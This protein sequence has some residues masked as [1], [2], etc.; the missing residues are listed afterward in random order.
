MV[1]N[2]VQLIHS[3]LSGDEQAFSTLVQKYQK[4]VH[5]LAWRKIGDFHIAEEITQD[6]FLQAYKNLATLR[7]PNQFAGWLYVIANRLC[8]KWI[9]KRK[10]PMQSLENMPVPEV[11]KSAYKRYV[12]E[13]RE[14]EAAERRHEIV[15]ELLEKLPESERTVVTLYYLGEMTTTEISKFLGVSV[16]TIKSRLRRARERLQA[17]EHLISETLE[18]VQL[19]A[20]LIEKIMQQ[21]ADI[22]PAS[23]SAGKPLLPWLAFGTAA[24][25]ILLM[26]GFGSE[27]LARFQKPYNLNA[28]SETTVEIIEAP[29]VLDTQ[30]EPDVRN[31]AGSFDT[32]GRS[33]GA[34]PQTS[35]PVLPAVAQIEKQEVLT[36]AQQQ[37]T[38]A[39]GPEGSLI[40]ELFVSSEGDIY[41]VSRHS[42][43]RLAPDAPAWTF[44]NPAAALNLSTTFDDPSMISMAEQNGTLYLASTNEVFISTDSG[45]AWESLGARPDGF[46]VGLAI[47]DEALYLV[48]KTNGIFRSVDAGKQ[49][50]RVDDEAAERQ[51]NAVATLENTVFVGTTEGLYRINPSNRSETGSIWEKLPLTSTKAIQSLATAENTLY[52]GTGPD[53]NSPKE[54]KIREELSAGR[55]MWEIF[56]STDFGDSWIEITPASAGDSWDEITP[57]GLL[58]KMSPGIK[59]VAAG[60]TL[61]ALGYLGS[62]VR[63]TDGGKTWTNP[64]PKTLD[65]VAMMNSFMLSVCPTVGVDENT[66]FKA[67][68]WGLTRSTDGGASWHP[69][70]TGMVGTRISDLVAFENRLYAYTGTN[71]AKSTDGGMSWQ[72]LSFNPLVWELHPNFLFGFSRLAVSDDKLYGIARALSA[73]RDQY[74]IFHLST[75]GDALELIQETPIFDEDLSIQPPKPELQ[76]VPEKSIADDPPNAPIENFPQSLAVSAETFYVVYKRQLFRWTRGE[77]EWFNTGLMDTDKPV[78]NDSPMRFALAV[79]GETVYV[80]KRDGHLF[81]SFD[82]GNTW[83]DLTATLPLRFNHFRDI[84]FV[85][86]TVYVATDA[87]VLKSQDSE[88][89]RAITDTGGTHTVI[90]RIAVH[91]TTVYG[92]GDTGVYQLDNRDRWKQILSDSPSRVIS[93]AVNGNTLYIATKRSGMF[94]ASLPEE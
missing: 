12:S 74:Y 70:M 32:T 49:W 63:S 13:Q 50:I 62:V 89:W 53:L 91:G 92:T 51:T 43:Y 20:N 31:Q 55:A 16:N 71:V 2:D 11:E 36:T 26:L 86:S 83:K 79:S 46:A 18:G 78:G 67:S 22:K 60:R 28:E 27:Y 10:T 24:L 41:A 57:E 52:V 21:V 42:L 54:G 84:T 5:A 72:T 37:W 81:R 75:K 34:G 33:S 3:V 90:D 69:F 82:R 58:M 61:W 47:T 1:E 66:L 39:S 9:Q 85:G 88:N 15:K 59:V 29:V 44:I 93:V 8:L 7:N 40:R 19:P 17:E 35:E 87:G 65:L 76:A 23:P 48:L 64:G 25:L 77:P 73:G 4:S 80:G 56:R 6:A 94:R 38:Q 30:A 14:Q 45:E 68:L